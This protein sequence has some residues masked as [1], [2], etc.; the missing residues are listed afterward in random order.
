MRNRKTLTR[1]KLGPNE[2]RGNWGG[3]SSWPRQTWGLQPRLGGA[4]YGA[5]RTTGP[6]L[7]ALYQTVQ[8]STS[9]RHLAPWAVD[10]RGPS[11]GIIRAFN[12]RL[13]A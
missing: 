1:T 9:P 7:R 10:S 5:R 3:P 12:D 13:Q 2:Y 11:E 6:E 4:S 8:Y